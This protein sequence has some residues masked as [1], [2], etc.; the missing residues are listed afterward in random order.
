M[1][2]ILLHVSA[3]ELEMLLGVSLPKVSEN[4]ASGEILARYEVAEGN[5]INGEV[6][7]FGAWF[8]PWTK[9]VDAPAHEVLMAA[10]K[11]K[12]YAVEDC[13][14][15][16][17]Y[18]PCGCVETT[19]WG[20]ADHDFQQAT[21]CRTCEPGYRSN[22]YPTEWSL[23]EE[24]EAEAQHET[25]IRQE[26]A[27]E[28]REQQEKWWGAIVR[29][30]LE[31]AEGQEAFDKAFDAC[32]RWNILHSMGANP[33]MNPDED[34]FA[35]GDVVKVSMALR[36]MDGRVT[37]GGEWRERWAASVL[38]EVGH[39]RAFLLNY[40][41]RKPLYEELEQAAKAWLRKE[42]GSVARMK[43]AIRALNN[44]L[45]QAWPK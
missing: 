20:H 40:A 32:S 17:H 19:R 34:Y 35:D 24:H 23:C 12:E 22:S 10:L 7:Q 33:D 28:E 30:M 6:G 45:E 11:G 5:Y 39:N 16:E 41:L 21:G 37:A 43:A 29:S 3:A 9:I 26:A 2:T 31:T 8:G 14:G 44:N 13:G 15:I 38:K 27:R 36:I 25:E 4:D 1:A 18:L 42:N